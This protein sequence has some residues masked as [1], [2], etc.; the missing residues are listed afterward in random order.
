MLCRHFILFMLMAGQ[1]AQFALADE[2]LYQERLR[3]QFH[4][5]AERNWL[6]DP[7]GLV[8]FDGKYH[9]FFQFNPR[10]NEWGNMTWGHALSP[11]LVHWRQLPDAITPDK[12][13][14]VFS[15]SAVVDWQN[16][17]GFQQ[18]DKPA[19]VAIYT[20]AGGTSQESTGA[21]FTQC[22]A[23]SN[24]GARTWT[25]FAGNP[26]LPNVIREN[27][28][29]KVIWH[30][31]TRR[32]VMA[33]YL[34][35]NEFA[36]FSS[37][38]LK[39]WTRTDDVSVPGSIECPDLFELP[40]VGRSDESKWIFWTANNVYLVGDFDGQKFLP[41][42]G[43]Q[44]FEFGANRFA[45]QTY[46][47]VPGNDGRRIQIA[48]M[49]GGS[50]PGMPFNQQMTFPTSLT[51]HRSGNAYELHSEPVAEIATLRGKP[52]HWK[53][54][55]R[56]EVNPLEELSGELYEIELTIAPADSRAVALDLRGVLV[57]Y[58]TE[59]KQLRCGE[60][61][62]I[63]P[64]AN[65]E[66]NLH[67]LLDRTSIEVFANHGAASISN[68]ILPNAKDRTYRLRGGAQVKSL[69]AWPL[70]SAWEERER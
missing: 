21:K 40:V 15:G 63:V 35:G 33:I 46:S 60:S 62:A 25:K 38:D 43:P 27:R 19:L 30:A 36:L 16:T 44:K 34:D 31:P 10:G 4:F 18:G 14:T 9:L 7:N 3:P 6:N 70:R 47:D 64:L 58:E 26:V 17:A 68:C 65:G 69:T 37:P 29:P 54:D 48:W 11:D 53:G 42:G 49:R 12:L 67:I 1:L 20:A 22:L 23:F 32:W 13:G 56:G 61:V 66:M 41:T 5:T 50:Y 59:T 8:Y 24:D 2:V 51:L 39:T 52:I 45:A 57:V 55:V 28:D